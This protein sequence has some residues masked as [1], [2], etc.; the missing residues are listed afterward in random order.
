MGSL[1]ERAVEPLVPGEAQNTRVDQVIW[2]IRQHLLVGENE[3]ELGKSR[4]L[5]PSVVTVAGARRPRRLRE[6][7]NGVQSPWRAR[8]MTG[9]SQLLSPKEMG[10]YRSPSKAPV[11]VASIV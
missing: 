8:I 11:R 7:P 6:A 5:I 4:A 2:D 3:V 9:E 10:R 1:L